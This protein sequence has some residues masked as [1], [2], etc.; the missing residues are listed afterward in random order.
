MDDLKSAR[1]PVTLIQAFQAIMQHAVMEENPHLWRG[2][3]NQYRSI[4]M[5]V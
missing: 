3:F 1:V 2:Y 4:C 5:I